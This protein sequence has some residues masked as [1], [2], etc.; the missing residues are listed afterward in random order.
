MP[1]DVGERLQVALGTIGRF[2]FFDLARELDRRGHL[3]AIFTGYPLSRLR[4]TG[5]PSARIR[6]FPWIQAPVV[7]LSRTGL[8][9][10]ALYPALDALAHRTLDAHIARNLPPCH[11]LSVMSSTGLSAGRAAQSRGIAYVCDR[12]STHALWRER[13]LVEEYGRLD[14]PFRRTHPALLAREQQE[15]EAAD[16]IAVPSGFARTSF[17]AMGVP[18]EKLR[19]IPYGVDLSAF[20]RTAP[21]DDGFRV[22]FVGQLSARKG[23]GYLLDGFRKARLPR[24]TLALVGDAQ[25]E[26]ETLLSR[27][28]VDRLERLGPVPR[29]EVVRQMSRASVLVLPSL[30]EGLALVQAQA[31]ACGCPVI[32]ST[33]TG[34]EDLFADGV[35]GF[36]VPI[37]NPDAIADRLTRLHDDPALL[38]RMSEAALERVKTIGGW[39]A[40]GDASLLLF[41]E[42]ARARGHD[43]APLSAA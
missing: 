32:A 21:R 43:I 31:M 35:E 6:R 3:A 7:G 34:S 17:T 15:Y 1:A 13:L 28:P 38:A 4:D 42:L 37:R 9:P 10:A 24:A 33:N 20:R 36:V 23:L 40:Y 12:G 26:T 18:A 2:H 25:P 19:V 27:F 11:V 29:D 41:H 22:L 30:E 14:L 8:L 5:V 39:A 16:A